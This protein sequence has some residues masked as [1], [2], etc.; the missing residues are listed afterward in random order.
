MANYIV[1]FYNLK[2]AISCLGFLVGIGVGIFLI[3]KKQ[4]AVGALAIVGFLLFSLDPL[5]DWIRRIIL[6]TPNFS[7]ELFNALQAVHACL[8]GLGF[9]LGTAA[10]VVAF[11]IVM[12]GNRSPSS[13]YSDAPPND[14]IE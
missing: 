5:V 2:N 1:V 8:S 14:S 6:R 7:I 4:R 11:I 3:V 10:L 9:F 13:D 12:R